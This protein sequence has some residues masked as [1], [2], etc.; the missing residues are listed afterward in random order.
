MEGSCMRRIGGRSKSK[1]KWMIIGVL[2]ALFVFSTGYA[3]LATQL[4]IRGTSQISANFNVYISSITEKK[5]YRATTNSTSVG[6]DKLTASFDVDLDIPGSYAE[7]TV[8]VKNDSSFNVELKEITGI[9]EAN[10]SAPKEIL[11]STNNISAGEVLEKGGTK[12]FIV[13]VD[14]D[15]NAMSLPATG[16]TL[17]I[18]LN[19][20]QTSAS[21]PSI[22]EAK[23]F[24][25]DS[26]DT[27]ANAIREGNYPYQVGDTKEVMVGSLGTFTVRV[28]NTSTPA[29]CSRSGFS[30]SACG[31]VVEFEDVVTDHVMNSAVTNKG[32]Y[33]S[34]D[35]KT[36][37]NGEFLAMLPVDLQRNIKTTRVV[38]G[39]GVEDINNFT[40]IEKIY[41]L[42]TMEVWGNTEF[43]IETASGQMRQ[44]DYYN[45]NG[46][47]ESNYSG[48][49][50]K[51]LSGIASTWWLRTASN[52]DNYSFH[53]VDADGD[54]GSYE[55]V[56]L[57]S[58][59]PAFRLG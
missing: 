50:K 55:C 11:Y 8:M 48:A 18:G 49:I 38:S 31:F 4:N 9:D 33:P 27:I 43:E 7:Y 20:E 34:S 2:S 17:E 21:A 30:Q 54:W 58:V 35:M 39:Y 19:Y 23:D 26:W 10:Q 56:A 14:F 13:R 12:E 25:L 40:S 6:E 59:S 47:T 28:A 5:V 22:G 1:Q 42:S 46:I 45:L 44:L 36:Y 32:G 15:A 24:A 16:K 3:L 57:L 29:E 37:L 41:L 51:D 53:N 52:I